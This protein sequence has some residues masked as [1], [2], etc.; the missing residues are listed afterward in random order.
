MSLGRQVLG[1]ALS[2]F[3]AAI[4]ASPESEA[5]VRRG[6]AEFEAHRYRDAI[7]YFGEAVKA[8]PKDLHAVFLQGAALNRL[9]SYREAF[10]L[11]RSLEAQGVKHA[12][13]DFEAGWALMGIGEAR[14]CINRLERFEKTAPGRGQTSEFL[15]R[16]Y[17]QLRE[18]DRAETLLKQATEREPKLKP[19]VN[20]SLARLEQARNRPDA[21]RERLKDAA[22]ANAPTGR[23]LRNILGL[24]EPVFQPEQPLRLSAAFSIGHNDNVIGLGSTIPL[25]ADIT[26]EGA[27]FWR[28]NFG[29][30]YTRALAAQT[31]A[32]LG[33]AL[34]V[35]RY[36][37]L[38]AADVNDHFLYGDLFHVFRERIGASL[39]L[40]HQYT[41]LGS[42]RFRD[43]T[44]LRPALSYRFTENSVTEAAYSYSVA[45]HHFATS[46]VFSRDGHA[47]ELSATHQFRVPRSAW[48]GT[49]GAAHTRN[50]AEGGDFNFDSTGISSSVRYDFTP[51]VSGA[52]GLSYARSDF[53]NPN[54][55][56][57]SGFSFARKD[58]QTAL[59]AQLAGR[60]TE[61]LRWFVQAQHLRNDSNIAFFEFKQNTVSAGIAANF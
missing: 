53:R 60:L 57:G 43:Q 10:L 2:C 40:S 48:S 46:P 54:S 16:C 37:G 21:A 8:D 55:L 50:R 44:A 52:L 15:G 14:A 47:K 17:L 3:A 7:H 41:E 49:V 34:L 31:N 6:L 18:F 19:S 36:H 42:S 51:R 20:L 59:S 27:D 25:P 32:T 26:R 24:P 38:P 39:R 58:E 35:D 4:A 22:E 5:L 13:M 33:Y 11:F 28:A 23:A 29:A 9:G 56:A 45:D 1:F 12:E 30:S 61:R